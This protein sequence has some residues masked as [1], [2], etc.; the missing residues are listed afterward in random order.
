MFCH[1][2]LWLKHSHLTLNVSQEGWGWGWAGLGVLWSPAF[3][4]MHPSLA[5]AG[6]VVPAGLLAPRPGEDRA[7]LCWLRLCVAVQ[8]WT[9][10]YEQTHAIN[11]HF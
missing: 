5:V 1:L 11:H 2:F 7:H 10:T 4:S 8:T 9:F 6:Q 3:G